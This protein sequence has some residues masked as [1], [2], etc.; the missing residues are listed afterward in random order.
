MGDAKISFSIGS[1]SFSGEGEETWLTKQL[2]KIIEKTPELIK[3]APSL[4]GTTEGTGSA[5]PSEAMKQDAAIAAQTLPNFLKSK[6]ATK[7]V[8]PKFLATAIW[9]HAKGSARLSTKDVVEALK[10]SN[11]ARL[12][13]PSDCLSK[14]VAKGYAE[15]DGKQ[16]FVTDV[17]KASL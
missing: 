15:R 7:S 14:N 10:D 4:P 5:V 2:D 17:G 12:G 11:Q 16:F 9:L 13:N 6:N 1:I 8:L 3:L